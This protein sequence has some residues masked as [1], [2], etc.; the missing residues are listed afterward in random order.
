MFLP[1]L[2]EG[3]LFECEAMAACVADNLGRVIRVIIHFECTNFVEASQTKN[4]DQDTNSGLLLSHPSGL[5]PVVTLG[6][7][8]AWFCSDWKGRRELLSE[9]VEA[10]DLLGSS[11]PL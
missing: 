5:T 8:V 1:P 6:N 10:S 7:W 2:L 9:P 11:P 4:A 3:W